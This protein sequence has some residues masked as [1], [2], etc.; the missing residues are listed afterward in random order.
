MSA[1]P[2]TALFFGRLH[3][4]LVHLPIGLILLLAALEVLGRLPRFRKATAA[5]GLVLAMAVPLAA[6]TAVCG[7]LLS[8]SGGYDAHLLQW[9][10]WTGVGT[11]AAC[12]LAGLLYW[13]NYQKAY[14]CCLFAT[15]VALAIAGHLGGSLTHGS[16]Y[17]TRYAPGPLRAL[18]GSAAAAKT[19]AV[20]PKDFAALPA[21]AVVEPVFQ[22]DCLTCH[23]PQKTK[24]GLRLDSMAAILKG[25]KSGPV[26]S[27][28]KP[29]DS[30]LFV[31]VTLPSEDDD[32]MPPDGKPQPS[33]DDVALL[34]WWLQ[35]GAPADKLV[36]E[37]KPPAAITRILT[38]RFGPSAIAASGAAPAVAPKPLKAALPLASSMADQLGIVIYGMSATEP[39]LQ[40]NASVAGK[41][42]GDAQLA[43]LAALGPNLRW[44]DLGGTAVTDAGLAHLVAMPNL[45]RLH[46][47]RTAVTDAGLTNLAGM[48]KLHSLDLYGTAVTDAGLE[49]LQPLPQL[50]ELYLWKTKVTP[51]AAKAFTE[52][53][54]DKGQMQEWE[55]QIQE[56]QA[57]LRAQQVTVD[58]GTAANPPSTA[59]NA[60]A[61]NPPAP[62]N[63]LCPVSGKP[64]DRTKTVLHK[65]KLI[66]FC[67]DDCKAKFQKHPEAYLGKLAL[68][69]KTPAS[70]T[71]QSK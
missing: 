66:A 54:L 56:L 3:P 16:D 10:K 37:L 38:A 2:Q 7:W 14:R 45:T 49:S 34:K 26:I 17:L 8:L 41:N 25:G 19:A 53:H 4:A 47:E 65:G 9:H 30:E 27:P 1:P 15:T 70:A 62:V 69:S 43:K 52:A 48:Q 22:K 63:A 21:F 12:A 60:A 67:C 39:W 36:R 58:L 5:T 44:L 32:H 50:K 11:A 57:K 6:V 51:A 31:R 71:T 13:L 40:C 35:A 20:R 55:Q 61:A 33:D 64:V 68:N 46:L 28:G 29:G 24:G 59:T 23:G 18:L 42:F